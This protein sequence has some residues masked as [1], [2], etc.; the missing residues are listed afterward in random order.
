[1]SAGELQKK[2]PEEWNS[3]LTFSVVR[4]PWDRIISAFCYSKR[5]SPHIIRNS[6]LLRY[7]GRDRYIFS[8]A[9]DKM[10]LVD[11]KIGVDVVLRFERLQADFDMLCARLGLDAS[12]QLPH[13]NNGYRREHYSKH[14]TPFTRELIRHLYKNEIRRFG[15]TFE[16]EAAPYPFPFSNQLT[17]FLAFM[18]S[19]YIRGYFFLRTHRSHGKKYL[20]SLFMFEK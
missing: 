11:K 13:V 15:Y 5:Y 4:N 20:L 14:Y 16:G 19:L 17:T 10:L 2:Y 8:H 9:T 18:F 3:Y 12:S 1:M 6:S 7:I